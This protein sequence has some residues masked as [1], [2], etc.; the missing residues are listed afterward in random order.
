MQ[1]EKNKQ[2]ILPGVESTEV[3]EEILKVNLVFVGRLDNL[4]FLLNTLES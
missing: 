3:A 4:F 1:V 2:N